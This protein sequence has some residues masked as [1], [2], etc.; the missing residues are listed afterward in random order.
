M[1]P[2]LVLEIEIENIM[3]L[4]GIVSILMIVQL[5]RLD[6]NTDHTKVI[7]TEQ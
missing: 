4:F 5:I 2:D 3:E 6:I 1:K 7:F